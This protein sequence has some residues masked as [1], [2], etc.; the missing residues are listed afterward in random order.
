MC[1]TSTYIHN[2]KSGWWYVSTPLK[3]MNVNWDDYSQLNG[4]MIKVPN[5]QPDGSE[6]INHNAGFPIAMLDYPRVIKLNVA[7]SSDHL[8]FHLELG[9]RFSTFMK[10]NYRQI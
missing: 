10:S 4:K 7:V 6:R 1:N 8:M 5:H 3:N 9:S 2:T